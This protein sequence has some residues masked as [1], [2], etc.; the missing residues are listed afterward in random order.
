MSDN[1]SVWPTI[2]PLVA[3]YKLIDQD[4]NFVS[5]PDSQTI[6]ERRQIALR[7]YFDQNGFLTVNA[8]D[9]EGA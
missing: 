5:N 2:K 8:F 4:G 3:A 1:H 7:K 6:A 9:D